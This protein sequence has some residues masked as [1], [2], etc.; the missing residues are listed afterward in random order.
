MDDEATPQSHTGTGDGAPDRTSSGL[1]NR[2]HGV[3]DVLDAMA[4]TRA[5][6]RYRSDPVPEADLATILFAA[7]RAPSGSNRQGFGFLV[8]RDGPE[9]RRA[10][11]MIGEAARGIWASK[12]AS[13]GYDEG[14]GV[15]ANSPKARMAA[16]MESFVEGF[17][18]IPV[19][20][21]VTMRRSRPGPE[22]SIGAS[23]YPACQNFLLAAR[24]LGYGATMMTWHR[25][26]E[27]DLRDVLGIP[28]DVF[29]AATIT[30][31][32]PVGRQGPVRRM[33]LSE[34]VYDGRW[35]ATAEWAVDPPDTRHTSWRR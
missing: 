2:H 5:M 30:M 15:S 20:T 9:A 14:S 3:A 26:V 8:L 31:G 21:L 4:T 17:E 32:V 6:R 24:A 27:D 23:V 35:G 11:S 1:P 16:T 33:P 10:K 28:E 22:E 19:V 25:A 18:S 7:T 34:F 12:R 29:L 13:D